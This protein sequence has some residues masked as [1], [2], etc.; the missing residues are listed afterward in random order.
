MARWSDVLNMCDEVLKDA[1]TC[2]SSPGAPMAIDEDQ[3]LLPDVTSVLS[4]T[5]MLF[6]N[7]FTRSIYSSTDVSIIIKLKLLK[8]EIYFRKK[9]KGTLISK[10]N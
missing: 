10:L 2:T 9:S 3:N 7:T 8:F 5:A 4:F 1:V 6:E